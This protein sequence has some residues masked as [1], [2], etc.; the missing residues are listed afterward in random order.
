MRENRLEVVRQALGQV[1]LQ[2][3]EQAPE[4]R[5]ERR[6]EL[7]LHGLLDLLG[8]AGEPRIDGLRDGSQQALLALALGLFAL[9]PI[10]LGLGHLAVGVL[11]QGAFHPRVDAV[12][13]AVLHSSQLGLEIACRRRGGGLHGHCR[14]LADLSGRGA[15]QGLLRVRDGWARRLVGTALGLS[16]LG[17][18][19]LLAASCT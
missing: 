17:L 14:R 10:L 8:N 11:L 16:G 6:L 19:R 18:L 1:L 15:G 4:S 3:R 12:E 5:D 13:Q 7:L 9:L 2:A